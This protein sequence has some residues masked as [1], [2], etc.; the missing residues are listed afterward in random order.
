MFGG[1]SIDMSN[2]ET[3]KRV[4]VITAIARLKIEIRAYP[5]RAFPRN[6]PSV[7]RALHRQGFVSKTKKKMLVEIQDWLTEQKRNDQP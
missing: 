3:R 5:A 1:F 6:F 4:I 2:L 7:L